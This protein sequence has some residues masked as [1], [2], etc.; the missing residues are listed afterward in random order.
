MAYSRP[1]QRKSS[2]PPMMRRK[3][4]RSLQYRANRGAQN[5]RFARSLQSV[6]ARPEVKLVD[7]LD[8]TAGS[9]VLTINSTGLVTPVN[10]ISGG[11][12]FNNRVGR[13]IEMQSLHFTGVIQ[14]TA[15]N[16]QVN[17]YARIM[18]IYDRQSNGVTPSIQT[19]LASYDQSTTA[20]TTVFSGINP[21]ERERFLILSDQRLTLPATQTAGGS[22]GPSGTDGLS[23]TW[24][25]NRFIKLR[26][27]QTHYKAD[28][29][30]AV[31]GDIATGSLLIVTMGGIAAASAPYQ[32]VGSWRLRYKDT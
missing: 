26:N 21:D 23:A 6:S 14:Q 16:S 24:N 25:I 32:F 31:I 29:T 10:L 28:S 2:R 20:Q 19:I 3:A 11:S 30:P 12:G 27:L 15:N 8:T 22:F 1:F 7:G 18:V 17:E 4:A 5:Y 9:N 13:K